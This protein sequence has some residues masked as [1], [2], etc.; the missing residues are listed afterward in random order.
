MPGDCIPMCPELLL[1]G[2]ETAPVS[3]APDSP[4]GRFRTTSK[5]G[6]KRRIRSR[7][8]ALMS[9]QC[10]ASKQATGE[11][12]IRGYG[13]HRL[14]LGDRPRHATREVPRGRFG[15]LHSSGRHIS[16]EHPQN[17]PRIGFPRAVA[18]KPT[19]HAAYFRRRNV[20]SA[21]VIRARRAIPLLVSEVPVWAVPQASPTPAVR[22]PT[23]DEL[24]G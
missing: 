19:P 10:G 22:S 24:A 18:T 16:F 8:R 20:L 11:S 5:N 15:S 1:R 17:G 23:T 12:H 9:P 21:V 3:R 13:C 6:K 2:R 4:R 7:R 14:D